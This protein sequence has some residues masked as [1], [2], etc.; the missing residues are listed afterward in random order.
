LV[1]GKKG[2]RRIYLLY[3]LMAGSKGRVCVGRKLGGAFSVTLATDGRLQQ[4]PKVKW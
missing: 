2:S 3:V 1:G 4:D